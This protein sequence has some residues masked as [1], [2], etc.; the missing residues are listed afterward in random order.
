[1][2]TIAYREG[3]EGADPVTFWS[4]KGEYRVH[5]AGLSR[6]RSH[7]GRHSYKLDITFLRDSRNSFW[8]GPV[9]DLPA[10]AGTR[11]SGHLWLERVPEHVEVSLGIGFY[12]PALEAV[13]MPQARG[14][15]MMVGSF[16]EHSQTGCWHRQTSDVGLA[17]EGISRSLVGQVTPGLR[18]EKWHIN[19]Q[20]REAVDERLVLY[21]D[22]IALEGGQIPDDW[23]AQE[24]ERLAAWCAGHRARARDREARFRRALAPIH[25]EA[26]GV[27]RRLTGLAPGAATEGPW[28]PFARDLVDEA[29]RLAADLVAR[30]AP[31]VQVPPEDK[32]LELYLHDLGDRWLRP[33]LRAVDHAPALWRRQASYLLTACS[34]PI[35][36][37]RVLPDSRLLGGDLDG[38]LDLFGCAGQAVPAA[39]VVVPAR[40]TVIELATGDL[41]GEAGSL[42]AGCLDLKLVKVWYQAGVGLDEVGGRVLTPELLLNDDDL[43]RVDTARQANLVRD[44]DAPR[45]SPRLLPVRVA[46]RTAQQFW[47]TVRVPDDAAPGVYRGAIEVRMAGIGRHELP[48]RLTVPPFALRPAA[49]H[50]GIYYRGTLSAGPPPFVS[51]EG[52]TAQQ[53][54]AEFRDLK[55]HGILYPDVY[56]PVG[57]RADGTLDL[58]DLERYLD[59]RDRAG[60]PRDQLFYDGRSVGAPDTEEGGQALVAFCRQLLE[61]ARAR[62][63][64]EVYFFG[65]DEAFGEQLA[66]Q[67]RVWA[68]VRA[69]GGRM[70]V[71]C[72][73]GF[74]DLV[75]DLLDLPIVAGLAPEEVPRVHA[76]GHRICNYSLPQGGLEQPFT[77]RYF[78][79]HWLWRSGMDGSRTYAYQHACGPGASMG[80]PWDDFD[81]AV[82][83]SLLLT[84]PTVDGVVGTLQWEGVRAAVDDVRYATTLR[85][86][87]AEALASGDPGAGERAREAAAWL[88]AVDILGDLH[89]VRRGMAERI[90]ALTGREGYADGRAG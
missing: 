78:F 31:D 88:D 68:R 62:G 35:S 26:L 3:F 74:F 47:V 87:I 54:E 45:D 65:S 46:A 81:N 86:A 76:I 17:A 66:A 53:L 29:G 79:G 1:M 70:T 57:V 6:E 34:D 73:A 8:S 23:E 64:E 58:A 25:A 44:L 7:G 85:A 2:R 61:W 10:V 67:R 13:G 56:Q 18:F 5:F 83:R 28:V 22:D 63:F 14:S 39:F 80:R 50:Y 15:R 38:R 90:L 40:Q 41:R 69:L 60:L 37:H 21:V 82:Y 36:N 19:I 52:K 75:G 48:V 77:Y 4:A 12:L 71:A 72:S 9:L 32:A 11:F 30:T 42:D 20:C 55:A 84:Y 89:A 27:W 16:T 43:V 59:I 51:S 33:L 49:L 24:E